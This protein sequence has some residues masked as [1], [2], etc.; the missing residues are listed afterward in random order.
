[1]LGLLAGRYAAEA[2]ADGAAALAAVRERRPDLVLSAVTLP[3]L[4]DF[5]LLRALRADPGTA[6]VPVILLAPPGREGDCVRGPGAGADD[7]LLAPFGDR[8]L[9]ARVEVHLKMARVRRE[10][11]ERIMRTLEGISDGLVIY[12]QQW[13]YAYVNGRAEQMLGRNRADLLGKSARDEFPAAPGTES[14]R[15]LRRAA[16]ERVTCEFEGHDADRDRW[17][18]NRAV[19]TPEGGVAVYFRDVTDRKRAEEKLRH[20]EALLAEAQQLAHVGSWNWD[21][22]ADVVTWS[23]ETFR[24]FDQKPGDGAPT[25]DRFVSLVHPDDRATVRRVVDESLRDRRPFD[26]H[27]RALRADGAVRVA[28]SRGQLVLNEAGEPV[29]MFGTV[30]DVTERHELEAALRQALDGLERRV[31][32]RTAELRE[33]QRRALQAERLAAIGQT[34]AGLAHESGNALQRGRAAL[35]RLG[36]RL[37]DRPEALPLLGEVRQAL[38]DLQRL[39]EDVRG[40]A[41]PITLDY[42]R[43]CDLV[44]VWRGAWASLE[45]KRRGRDARL[46]E[47]TAGCATGCE[48][49]A[50]RLAQVFRNLFDN[51]LA[52][53]PDPAVVAV[54]CTAADLGGRPAVRAAVF[55]NGPGLPAGQR[56]RAFEPF[57]T[58]KT[59]GTGLGLAIARRIVEAHGGTV[60]A[61]EPSG[62][63]A[64]F[65][66]TLPRKRP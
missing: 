34:V 63:G 22:V 30:Q 27:F 7:Y 21:L 52:A 15:Q 16:A 29:R 44:A 25:F 55:D 10:A 32:E 24:I 56:E 4:A 12:D 37:E 28:H 50:F 45:G 57:F 1:L 62:P 40:Y 53:C 33:S 8:E 51:A 41:A 6:E 36:W 2:A 17:Y 42:R 5:G 66:V 61:G 60:V 35:D 23:D 47:D 3:R 26:F 46:Q 48:G 43:C 14:E 11:G 54:R 13:R 9:L 18:E 31:E 38:E 65:V 58:T 64:E 39:Y 49:D 20:S 19:P 59:H